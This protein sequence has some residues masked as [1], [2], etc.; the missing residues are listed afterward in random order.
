VHDDLEVARCITHECME[1]ICYRT[2]Y[3]LNS[4]K[5]VRSNIPHVPKA[6]YT[7]SNE[8][9][10]DAAEAMLGCLAEF[11]IVA[12]LINIGIITPR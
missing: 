3:D 7:L 9:S 4:K 11:F 6:L 5:Y 8:T 10:G 2:H 12:K 1:M